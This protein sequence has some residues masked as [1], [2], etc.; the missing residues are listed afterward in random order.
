VVKNVVKVVKVDKIIENIVY[1]DKIV[2]VPI[3]QTEVRIIEE[4]K[5][6]EEVVEKVVEIVVEKI[7]EVPIIQI[8]EVP[9]IVEKR[10][11]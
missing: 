9:K 10:T 1:V 3:N 6:V 11:I 7:I 4:I 2:E 5:E 8:I